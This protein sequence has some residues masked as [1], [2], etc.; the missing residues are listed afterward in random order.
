MQVAILL[1]AA[2]PLEEFLRAGLI[3]PEIRLGDALFD[4]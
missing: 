2:A 4:A 1:E 3:L